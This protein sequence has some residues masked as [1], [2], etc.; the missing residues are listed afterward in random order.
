MFGFYSKKKKVEDA[1]KT[2]VEKTMSQSVVS[3]VERVVSEV[4]RKAI[5]MGSSTLL[6]RLKAG[7]K[8][9]VDSNDLSLTPH[10]LLDGYWEEWITS[11][12]LKEIRP[13]M[14]VVDIGANCGYY[15][16]LACK[17]VGPKGLVMAID[18]NPRMCDLVNRSLAVNGFKDRAKV[19]NAAVLDKSGQID[20]VV[21]RKYM[22]GAT[23]TREGINPLEYL[24][25]D[26]CDIVKVDALPL[27]EITGGRPV[28]VLKID[29]EGA[30]P[31][32][33]GGSAKLFQSAERMK[34]F[35]EFNPG[36]F[37]SRGDAARFMDQ[38]YH[39]GFEVKLIDFNGLA[40][41]ADRDFLV[42]GGHCDLL[43]SK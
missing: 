8:I 25:D 23:I 42:A 29:V 11:A 27:H 14:S 10:I 36:F 12:F 19:V 26:T 9:Y 28:D 30:E 20:F 18:A 1:E 3:E 2:R 33:F 32:V 21:P 22:G 16:L 37:A 6:T 43:L 34:V 39:L 31:A 5:Y 7:P 15:T 41:P 13:G 38:V 17:A 24:E 40:V 4:E 35:M